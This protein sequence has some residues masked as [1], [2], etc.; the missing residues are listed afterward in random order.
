MGGKI[1]KG[2]KEKGM[3][4]GKEDKGKKLES[5]LKSEGDE[6]RKTK[7]CEQGIKN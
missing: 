7:K 3:V 6:I 5:N 2:R 1:E 4:T